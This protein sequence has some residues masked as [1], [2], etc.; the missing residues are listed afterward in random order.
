MRFR[1]VGGS[2]RRF[3]KKLFQAASD[4]SFLPRYLIASRRRLVP[5][6]AL[7]INKQE[8]RD[9]QILHDAVTGEGQELISRHPANW[10]ADLEIALEQRY[11]CI[12]LRGSAALVESID[13]YIQSL[14]SPWSVLLLQF[15][16]HL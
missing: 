7:L 3:G 4:R 13:G 6:D 8:L 15:C 16:K 11:E 14:K 5:N 9:N 2:M 10:K 12:G 1:V